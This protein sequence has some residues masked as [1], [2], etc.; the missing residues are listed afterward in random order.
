MSFWDQQFAGEG[1]KYG[2]EP[3][4]FLREQAQ[5]LKPGSEVLLPGDGEGRNSVWLATQGYRAIALDSSSVGLDKA[6][7]LA[8]LRG[9]PLQTLHVDLAHWQP[10]GAAF[11]AVALIYLHLPPDVRQTALRQLFGVLRPQGWLL[12]EAFHPRQLG[13]GSGGPK[14]QAMLYTLA[15][16]RADLDGL[17]YRE[18]LAWE[19]EVDLDEG[20]GHHGPAF[21]T[22]WVIQRI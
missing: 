7:A 14:D 18:A 11:D 5:R 2:T 8:A 3:N 20:P 1:F 10:G 9:V 6:R 16:L 13:Y 22:R 4:V 17:P 21:V 12:L 19:G 15:M